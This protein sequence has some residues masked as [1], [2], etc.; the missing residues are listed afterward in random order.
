MAADAED[1][2]RARDEETMQ[3]GEDYWLGSTSSWDMAGN[4]DDGWSDVGWG[5]DD[6][7]D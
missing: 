7:N 1:L 3:Q 4:P 2:A 6:P 5:A